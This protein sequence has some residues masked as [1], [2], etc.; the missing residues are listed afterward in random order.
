MPPGRFRIGEWLVEPDRDVLIRGGETVKL[1]PRTMRVLVHLAERSRAVVSQS[2]LENGAW[3]GVI[4]TPESVYQ[5]I[6]QLRRVLG[7]DVRKPRYIETVPR[8]GYRLVA[9]VERLD[10][11]LAV[12]PP[13]A[14]TAS[15]ASA[16]TAESP[17]ITPAEPI[18]AAAVVP[19]DE[20][21]SHEWSRGKK[22][23][24]VGGAIALAIA[25]TVGAWLLLRGSPG[26][27]P[28]PAIA[29]LPFQDMSLEH[30]NVAFCDGL[31][32][33]LMS[34]LAQLSELRVTARNSAFMFRGSERDVRQIGTQLGVSHV[35]EGSV[36]RDAGRLRITA[37]LVDARTGFQL[38]AGNFDKPSGEVIRIQ[39]EIA[40][41][42]V[43][44]LRLKLSAQSAA[45]L[46]GAPV[47]DVS[48]YDLYLLG[49]YQQL[50]RTPEALDR[51][52]RY[53][54]GALMHDSRFALAYAG[55]ADAYMAGFYYQNRS[56]DQTAALV[57]PAA[58]RALELDP[59]LAEA[60]AARAVLRSEQWR[61][62]EAV[63]DL[64]KAILL[65]PNYADAL[66]R[67]GAAR[68]YRAEPR[69][70][71]A[72]YERA[73]DLDPLHFILHTRRC[74]T[75]QSLGRHSDAAQACQRAI[76]L[77]PNLPNAHWGL[78]L[79][80]LE[81]G[82]LTTAIAG[83]R[84]ALEK[85]P[86]RTDLLSQL[87]WLL[88]D[89][90]KPEEARA[91]FDSSLTQKNA[92]RIT[93]SLERARLHVAANDTAELAAFVDTIAL[94]STSDPEQ[95]LDGALLE[96]LAN[97]KPHALALAQRA[98]KLAAGNP[99]IFTG[100]WQAR[101]GRS[102]A[103]TL[104]LCANARGDKVA[105]QKYLNDLAAW[106]DR[107]IEQGSVWHGVHYL[108][109]SVLA[110]RGQTAEALTELEAAVAAGWRRGWWMRADPALASLREQP[111]FNALLA[112]LDSLKGR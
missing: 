57:E 103:L 100:I 42:V 66:V 24:W 68:E 94:D 59:S 86:W 73:Q 25:L 92:D 5:S 41:E 80:A 99:Q 56:L 76:D 23:L 6:A 36:R 58:A 27:P 8:K 63:A 64:D 111:R 82:D 35:L 7:D 81:Q 90:G 2:D 30:D 89:A 54:E 15:T 43:G 61:L 29:V 95:L 12:S 110:R 37:H 108:R 17:P 65:K 69:L 88:L 33:E 49:R 85:A 38:W 75:L 32:E 107:V 60:Y 74:L 45:R 109:G 31:T 70:A 18:A 47:V 87:G 91:A 98:E 20:P 39:E 51:A 79:N 78:A 72:A 71:M 48:A 26:L 14:P 106:L 112:R 104:A 9:D 83:Y 67:L 55:L 3:V 4:V 50:Q 77:Q 46:A 1:E 44:T 22:R 16:V 13:I 62:D 93:L 40:R 96:L 21:R 52:V 10:S 34:L 101:W 11:S 84:R 97:D 28:V 105:E 102:A 53:H 19:R